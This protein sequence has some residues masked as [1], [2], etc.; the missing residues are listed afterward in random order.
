M[1]RREGDVFDPLASFN[2]LVEIEGVTEAGFSEVTGF[3]QESEVIEYREGNE[4]ITVRKIPGLKK[5]SNVTLKRGLTNDKSLWD[6]RKKVMWPLA[7][8]P[9]EIPK[10]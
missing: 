5:F 6:W 2:F 8:P 3:D 9:V 10:M 7:F 4:D 1:A